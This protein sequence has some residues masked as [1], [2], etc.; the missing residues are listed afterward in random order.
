VTGYVDK[1]DIYTKASFLKEEACTP[2]E[3]IDFS[4]RI[5]GSLDTNARVDIRAPEINE[6][7]H[8]GYARGKVLVGAETL[9]VTV[10]ALGFEKSGGQAVFVDDLTP[11]SFGKF[12]YKD[13]TYEFTGCHDVVKDHEPNKD[14]VVLFRHSS[15]GGPNYFMHWMHYLY[16]IESQD[17][18]GKTKG[19]AERFAAEKLYP[20]DLGG[21]KNAEWFLGRLLGSYATSVTSNPVTV[22]AG[23]P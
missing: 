8:R 22:P 14:G 7:F 23:D 13:G 2:D 4:D 19:R 11:F 21:G 10:S 16:P 6:E 9:T 18:Q 12:E 17:G 3:K 5:F 1:H 15:R 20:I